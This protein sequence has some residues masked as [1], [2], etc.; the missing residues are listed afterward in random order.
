M[1][2]RTRRF[3]TTP[4]LS[5]DSASTPEALGKSCRPRLAVGLRWRLDLQAGEEGRVAGRAGVRRVQRVDRRVQ[6][7]GDLAQV[8][9]LHDRVL[10]W[11]ARRLATGNGSGR[12]ARRRGAGAATGRRVGGRSG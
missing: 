7:L 3:S 12:L 6:L 4:A 11:R 9:A 5:A 10:T 2:R 8:V 1:R